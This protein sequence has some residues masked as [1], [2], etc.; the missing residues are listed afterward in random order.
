MGK[1]EASKTAAVFWVDPSGEAEYAQ[2]PERMRVFRNVE[3]ATAFVLREL[4]PLFRPDVRILTAERTLMYGDIAV[5]NDGPFGRIARQHF[6]PG[7]QEH[8]KFQLAVSSAL[9]L[10]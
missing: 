4:A 8:R 3:E 9:S 6:G 2:I 1:N 10:K 7:G 5:R